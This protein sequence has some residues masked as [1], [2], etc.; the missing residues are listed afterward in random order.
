MSGNVWTFHKEGETYITYRDMVSG[1]ENV[2]EKKILTVGK[3]G[4]LL[5]CIFLPQILEKEAVQEREQSTVL[6]SVCLDWNFPEIE[7]AGSDEI[8][9]EK[10]KIAI[11]F[12]DGPHP[13]YT[14]QLLDGLQERNVKAA[15]FLIGEN[16]AAYPEI[17]R[18]E[19]EDGHL[20]GN[21]TF[22]H[23]DLEKVPEEIALQEIAM[24]NE[25]I[26][27][28]T[29]EIPQFVRPPFGIRK[30]DLEAKLT[31]LPVLWTIDPLD[32]N[33]ENVDEIVNKVV[34][35]A[36]D[37][38]IILLHDCYQSSVEAAFQIIDRLQAEGFAFVL[39]DQLILE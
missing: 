6:E 1:A 19:Y 26:A 31:E 39:P 18:R 13:R 35:K 9:K 36:K 21:H 8:L 32:W 15:F 27:E 17:V 30:K 20:I 22:H 33:T 5:C 16:A 14:G 11:T 12:D 29:G 38:D 37:G 34:T 10:P 28:V 3:V 24:T 4:L 25:V 7:Q 2:H 23:I